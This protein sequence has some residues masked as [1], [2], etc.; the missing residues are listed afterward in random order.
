MKYGKKL[1]ITC[2]VTMCACL[3]LTVST[4]QAVTFTVT[5]TADT[6]DGVCAAGDCSLRE[7]I[8]AAN[9][10]AGPDTIEFATGVF[11]APNPVQQIILSLNLPELL[12]DDDL[13]IN[14]PGAR[15]LLI[16]GNDDDRIFSIKTN[17]LVSIRNLAIL[18]GHVK[19]ASIGQGQVSDCAGGGIK[20]HGDLTLNR[21]RLYLNKAHCQ[22][23][24]IFNYGKLTVV[25]SIISN[26]YSNQYGGGI[27]SPNGTVK[28]ANTTIT[29]N[30]AQFA[31]GGIRSDADSELYLNN[32]T[33]S[34]NTAG[35][36]A[37]GI[38]SY[39]HQGLPI[40]KWMRNTIVANNNA[41]SYHDLLGVFNSQGSNLI[42]VNSA[43]VSFP[44]GSPN[45]KGDYVG[46]FVTPLDPKLGPLQDNGG[47]SNTRALLPGSPAI[48]KGDSCVTFPANC[49]ENKPPIP[50]V[51]DQR[52]TG[53]A[54]SSGASVDIG[55]FEVDSIP[56]L[57]VSNVSLPEGDQNT[58]NFNFV[59]TL[60]A[61]SAQTVSVN[62]QTAGINAVSGADFVNTSGTLSFAPGET[63]KQITVPVIGELTVET[64]EQ[65][66]LN[67]SAPVNATLSD[68]QGVGTIK[69]DDNG[70]LIKFKFAPYSGTENSSV[71]V[72][73]ERAYGT[74]G[75]V[76]VHYETSGGSATASVDYTPVSGD[77]T[78]AAGETTKT[79][80][81]NLLD[82][83]TY[84]QTENINLYLSNP[85]GK[86]KLGSP[87]DTVVSIQDNDA[88]ATASIGGVIAYGNTQANQ[89]QK[90]VPNAMVTAIGAS[91]VSVP[92]DSSGA[93]LLENLT[94]G[95]DYTV[96]LTKTGDRNNI[97][98][99]DATLVLK[100]VAANGQGPN[101]LSLNQQKAADA[102]GDGN[103]TP[104]D[105]TLI[106]R[107]VA[108]GGPT[109]NTGQTGNWKFLPG[110]Q[111]YQSLNNSLSG[112]DYEAVLIGEINGN[113]TPP[114]PAP[115]SLAP[116][117]NQDEI[118]ASVEETEAEIS[119]PDNVS[120]AS[121]SIIVVPV[122]FANK[123]GESISGYNFGVSFDPNV[124]QLD[125]AM[126][127]DTSATLSQE[128]TVVH[129]T[130]Q[131]G[132][133]GIAASGGNSNE[134][135][136][137]GDLL[138]K[139]RFRTVGTANDLKKTT[140]A[141]TFHQQPN[142]ENESGTTLTVK[143]ANGSVRVSAGGAG[144]SVTTI[145]GQVTTADGRGIRNVSVTLAGANGETRTVMT[146]AGGEYH[147]TDV[148]AGETYTVSVSS[149]RFRF[150]SAS[151]MR[152]IFAEA[153]EIN[154]TALE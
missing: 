129:N 113:W 133:I 78:F 22:G 124:L 7:A 12:I 102:N 132:R 86:A 111:N 76:S 71:L 23:G 153:E 64:D 115:G 67:L 2:F 13:T 95:S 4:A 18:N 69:D 150:N 87:A 34:H 128:M 1:F 32:A 66:N 43:N 25:Y 53:F 106:L 8:F 99:F 21:V 142:I 62:Y 60:S 6:D 52:Y 28:I 144:K 100:H 37:G 16:N 154:F 31:G 138:L 3:F 143:T 74:I 88:P 61:G 5:K 50:L 127:I 107:Y 90:F 77:L 17:R 126:P 122:A 148:Q 104:F 149:K 19:A 140:T 42:R 101:V 9:D 119:L 58:T 98:P 41:P 96:S 51:Y 56:T 152:T 139:L 54:R 135:I 121:G 10:L 136:S 116:M 145:S 110:T 80:T 26:N 112:E 103:I 81:I 47:L 11:A 44:V 94:T 85:T 84:E 108:A 97:S 70:G 146:G 130:A 93:Y 120:A 105:A 63:S 38:A 151:Q 40:N 73:V 30:E 20:N 59:V 33:I 114:A 46:T 79:F 109:A 49:A 89:P 125:S 48:D 91:A 24:G 68:A 75:T 92:T 45:N 35:N 14:G 65:F 72:T 57:S 147:F 27:Y 131:T 82:D 134:R 36:E 55:A 15:Q 83:Q 141:L 123:S 39:T 118:A 29:D 137:K 117:D